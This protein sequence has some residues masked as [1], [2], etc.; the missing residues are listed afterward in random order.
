MELKEVFE[1]IVNFLKNFQ[2][3]DKDAV[4]KEKAK[5]RLQLVLMQDRASVS[6]D[7]FEMMKKE[8][9]D[10]IKKYIEIDEE[11]LEVQLTRGFEGNDGAG[12][13]LYANI[14]IKNI[15][16]V[17]RKIDNVE[18]ETSDDPKEV[19]NTIIEEIK[20]VSEEKLKDKKDKKDKKKQKDTKENI[21]EAGKEETS[22]EETKEA[23]NIDKVEENVQEENKQ[24]TTSNMKAKLTG[25]KE[26]VADTFSKVKSSAKE[27][28]KKIR[29]KA[30][31]KN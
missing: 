6:P 31:A 11:T 9:I 24:D 18:E 16:P 27:R 10:V 17:A 26:G 1:P 28:F 23:E 25:V 4:S 7:F 30:K 20:T 15:K 14:P 8:I 5:E 2:R 3:K 22:N 21:D 29:S 19:A 12:P 13:A